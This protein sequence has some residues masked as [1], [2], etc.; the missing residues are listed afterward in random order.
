MKTP[1]PKAIARA[2]SAAFLRQ[3]GTIEGGDDVPVKL[4]MITT[5]S[6][7][8]A[9]FIASFGCPAGEL[10]ILAEWIP[11]GMTYDRSDPA[12]RPKEAGIDLKLIPSPVP[13]TVFPR[14]FQDLPVYY[15]RGQPAFRG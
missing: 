2:F 14:Q 8:A 4:L 10:A 3:T 13:W 15:K 6:S 12:A 1:N 11:S 9:D 5:T 7:G